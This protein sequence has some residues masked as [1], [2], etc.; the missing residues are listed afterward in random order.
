[1]NNTVSIVVPFYREWH[2]THKRLM[3]LYQYI[4]PRVEIVL[5][6]DCSMDKT[7]DDSILWWKSVKDGHKIVHVR[8]EE[9]I[10]F[11]QSM[12]IGAQNS[13]GDVIILYSN[14]VIASGN[15][16]P[17]VLDAIKSGGK[18]IVGDA[19]LSWNTGWNV[20]EI[21]GHLRKFPYL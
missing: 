17:E 4:H 9:N 3:E 6:D 13:S 10:G 18:C 8:N 15:F 5:V 2:L 16:V 7:I 14:D 19:L 1:M 12:N 21:N 20:I 11:G